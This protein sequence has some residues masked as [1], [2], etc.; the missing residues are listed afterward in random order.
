MY[1]IPRV[2]FSGIED[3]SAFTTNL[4]KYILYIRKTAY[5]FLKYS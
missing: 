2:Y 4:E 1:I 3:V 5:K